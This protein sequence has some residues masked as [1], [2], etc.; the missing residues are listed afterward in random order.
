MKHGSIPA[1]VERTARERHAR[2]WAAFARSHTVFDLD[3]W[4][5]VTQEVVRNVWQ[6]TVAQHAN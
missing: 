5:S 6:E 3:S 1:A 2:G 4:V